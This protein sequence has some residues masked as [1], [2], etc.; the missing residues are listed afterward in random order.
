MTKL[1]ICSFSVGKFTQKFG[2]F[3]CVIQDKKMYADEPEIQVGIQYSVKVLLPAHLHGK[4][5]GGV[6]K[7][8]VA[9]STIVII[10]CLHFLEKKY[11]YI[12]L[13]KPIRRFL[14]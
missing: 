12:I 1:Q 6:R 14:S 2:L 13:K 5:G 4:V 8:G 10:I 9:Q 3:V 7:K 11:K